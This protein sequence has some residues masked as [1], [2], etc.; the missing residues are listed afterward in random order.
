[1]TATATSTATPSS[2]PT[3]TATDTPTP[4]A[5]S[6]PNECATDADCDDGD[7]C[8]EDTCDLGTC[9]HFGAPQAINDATLGLRS[10]SKAGKATITVRANVHLSVPVAPV[11]DPAADGLRLQLLDG[12]GVVRDSIDLPAGTRDHDHPVGWTANRTALHWRYFDPT[13]T[14]RVRTARLSV[15]PIKG[16]VDVWLTALRGTLPLTSSDAPFVV[17]VRV[18]AGTGRC[19]AVSF[20]G[21]AGPSPTCR[22]SRTGSSILCR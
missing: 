4:T 19:G 5:T 16:G 7:L 18:G 22:F 3:A 9:V 15:D 13:G 14:G 17:Q 6:T 12:T 10:L 21:T 8:T 1:V 2:T 11:I 20:S